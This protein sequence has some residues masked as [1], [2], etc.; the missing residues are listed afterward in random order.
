MEISDLPFLPSFARVDWFC[1]IQLAVVSQPVSMPLLCNENGE[2]CDRFMQHCIQIY[3][4]SLL[5][6]KHALLKWCIVTFTRLNVVF[7]RRITNIE[8]NVT[9]YFNKNQKLFMVFR[10]V[11]TYLKNSMMHLE[12]YH[13]CI[14]H[15]LIELSIGK[16]ENLLCICIDK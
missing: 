12:Y 2:K 4:C 15:L 3:H 6:Q 9:D 13:R 8:R 16:D 7:L 14:F 10:H 11:C 1:S 5:S